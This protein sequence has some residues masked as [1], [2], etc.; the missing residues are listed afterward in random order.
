M[1]GRQ[2]H[3]LSALRVAKETAPTIRDDRGLSEAGSPK[4]GRSW[5]ERV[6]RFAS[7][8]R[9]CKVKRVGRRRCRRRSPTLD[10]QM[11]T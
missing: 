5:D 1:S 9:G 10:V 3:R 4:C 2:L 8:I 7:V 11:L 6:R